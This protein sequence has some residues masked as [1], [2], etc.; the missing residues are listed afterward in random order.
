[1]G[2]YELHDFFLYH[3]VHSG[4]SPEKIYRLACQVW[5]EKEC[6]ED[7][8]YDEKTILHW[9]KNFCRRFFSQAFKR[10]CMPDGVA[11]T[12]V[13][14]SPRAGFRMPSDALSSAWLR[15]LDDM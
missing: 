1:M 5:T 3:L 14:L 12:A 4:F 11:V 2:P 7:S 15:E 9:L 13:S 6:E 8:V 10:S